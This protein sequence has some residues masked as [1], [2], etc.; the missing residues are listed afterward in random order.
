MRTVADLTSRDVLT[1]DSQIL[2]HPTRLFE[3]FVLDRPMEG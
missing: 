3:L 2:F 1:Y